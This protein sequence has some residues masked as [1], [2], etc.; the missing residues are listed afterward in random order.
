MAVTVRVGLRLLPVPAV[1]LAEE[2]ELGEGVELVCPSRD[3]PA[4]AVRGS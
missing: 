3:R 4:P 2:V 1:A